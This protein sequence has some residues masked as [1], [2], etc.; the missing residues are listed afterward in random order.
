[1][2]S[3]IRIT[4]TEAQWQRISE[5]LGNFGIL[6]FGTAVVPAILD[7]FNIFLAILGIVVTVLFWYAS[8]IAAR[9]Y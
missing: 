8:I 4:L 3:K 1:M 7:K 9:K 5:I 2:P 6:T